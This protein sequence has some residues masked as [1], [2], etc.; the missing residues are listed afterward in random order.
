LFLLEPKFLSNSKNCFIHQRAGFWKFF[1]LHSLFFDEKRQEKGVSRSVLKRS[2]TGDLLLILLLVA[3]G[4]SGSSALS[5][6]ATGT[7]T[8]VGGGE[9]EVNVLLGVETDNEGGDIDDLLA[10]AIL[11]EGEKEINVSIRES[12]HTQQNLPT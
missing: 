4:G 6:D 2:E 11:L 9:R 5:L 3:L 1:F 8:T 7:S 12:L 10:D